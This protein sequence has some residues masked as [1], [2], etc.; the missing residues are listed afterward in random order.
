MELAAP[1]GLDRLQAVVIG[2]PCHYVCVGVGVG[3]AGNICLG[4]NDCRVDATE[5][6]NHFAVRY[7]GRDVGCALDM[8]ARHI[9]FAGG[10]PSDQD[11][12][13]LWG[14]LERDQNHGGCNAYHRYTQ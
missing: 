5:V 13:V 12:V 1:V 4:L 6:G 10:H 8:K 9:C 7:Y 3:G 2:R 14:S 11:R